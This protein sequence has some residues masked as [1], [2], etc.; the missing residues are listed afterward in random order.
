MITLNKIAKEYWQLSAKRNKVNWCTS[1]M[2]VMCHISRSWRK[3]CTMTRLGKKDEVYKDI[4]ICSADIIL[5]TLNLLSLIECDDIESL[6]KYRI[7]Q[8]G[9]KNNEEEKTFDS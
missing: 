8:I 1:S 6:I 3:I 7:K 2:A 9:G 4:E 5:D